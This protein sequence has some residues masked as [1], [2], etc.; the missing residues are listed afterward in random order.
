MVSA[1]THKDSILDL[2]LTNVPDR[3]SPVTVCD[4]ILGTDHDTV[5]FV[6]EVELHSKSNSTP[7]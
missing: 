3:I 1:N 2:V 6:I 7:R 5:K 4:N